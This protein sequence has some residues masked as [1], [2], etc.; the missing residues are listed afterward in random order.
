MVPD[1]ITEDYNFTID[2][3]WPRSLDLVLL[4]SGVAQRS[5]VKY[6][7]ISGSQKMRRRP[8]PGICKEYVLRTVDI[9]TIID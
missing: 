4:D 7:Y 9:G 1:E 8:S 3:L 2:E 6:L 5:K